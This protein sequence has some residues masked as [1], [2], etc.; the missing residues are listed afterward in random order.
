MSKPKSLQ[1]K[2]DIAIEALRF[3]AEGNSDLEPI[4]SKKHLYAKKGSMDSPEWRKRSMSDYI[5]G[6]VARD[7]LAKIEGENDKS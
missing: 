6:K 7:T 3:Y 2:L 1:A 4:E 5:T